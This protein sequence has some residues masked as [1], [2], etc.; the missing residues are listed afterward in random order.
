M[1]ASA[2]VDGQVPTN[3]A[4]LAEFIADPVKLKGLFD[5]DEE[6]GLTP[7]AEFS[8]FLAELSEA[9]LRTDARIAAMVQT[10]MAAN[11]KA[12]PTKVERKALANGQP[13]YHNPNAPGAELD[14]IFE[15]KGEFL[16]AAWH[17][18]GNL[19]N[20]DVLAPKL[21]KARKVQNAMS[22]V[23][24][25]DGGFLIPEELRTDIMAVALQE[26]LTRQRAMVMPMSSKSLSLPVVDETSRASSIYGGW[27]AYRTPESTAPSQSSPKFGRVVL[28]ATKLTAL[29][30]VP[31]E[32]FADAV[33]LERFVMQGLPKVV[34]DQEERDFMTGSG[35]G[36][37]LGWLDPDNDALISITRNTDSF[38]FTDI[39]A[40]FARMFSSSHANA[41]WVCSSETLPSLLRAV[42]STG[43][44]TIP[45][46]GPALLLQDGQGI[47]AA[48]GS[49]LGKPL[50]VDDNAGQVTAAGDLA[51]VDLAYYGIG[52][53]QDATL[54]SST[55]NR[56][57]EDETVLKC[58]MRNDGRPL[59]LSPITPPNGGDTQSA[60]V[61]RAA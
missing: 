6:K 28:D 8:A 47:K 46:V 57:E 13:S 15:S 50:L 25:A 45:V 12:D 58:I 31:N 29:T 54:S 32:L 38:V 2:V 40:M 49:I 56:F 34:R 16:Q 3:S 1:P 18:A 22:S 33:G 39:T 27:V 43:N 7:K 55:D 60:F 24:P 19:P 20:A 41:V 59:L 42:I 51:Y 5:L 35:V 10:Q 30:R 37:P 26:S 53:R 23:V 11:R 48:A 14:G 52:D 9:E 17:L 61:T 4:E 36:E 21:A 44:A